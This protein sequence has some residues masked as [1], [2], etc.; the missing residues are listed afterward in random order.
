MKFRLPPELSRLVKSS[1]WKAKTANMQKKLADF[2]KLFKARDY[3]SPDELFF[4]VEDLPPLGKEYWFLHF[5][6][7]PTDSQVVITLGR[8]AERVEVNQSDVSAAAKAGTTGGGSKIGKADKAGRRERESI[9]CAAVCWLYSGKKR[10]LFDSV[11]DVRINHGKAERELVAS[12]KGNL[13]SISGD[14]PDFD[15]RLSQEG[16]DIFFARACFPRE[17]IPYEMI[18]LLE[19][20]LVPKL[21]SAMINY[22]FDFNG[23]LLGKPISGKAYL[24]KV[25]AVMPLAPWNWVRVN[26]Q[27]NAC[28]DFFE[29]KPLGDVPAIHFADNAYFE[30]DGARTKI[31]GNLSLSSFMEGE[32]KVWVLSGK[33][34]FLSMR[35][36]SLQPF[37]MRQR[38][39]FRYDE[40][41][42]RVTDFA[43]KSGG[44]EYSFSSLGEGRG[45][46]EEASGYLL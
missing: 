34:F 39:V 45:I 27:N 14:Y 33:D 43:F 20:P 46:V 23:T 37:I 12:A 28:L 41:L 32:S 5:S 10:V 30:K 18:H 3:S 31:G 1:G 2:Y 26:F 25:V 21:S 40:Y 22:Y 24:Q 29:G 8:S 13:A 6:A 15:I 38:T 11:A 7:P 36:Y 16:K 17:G 9:K 44:K 42:V 35:T 4:S 19:T